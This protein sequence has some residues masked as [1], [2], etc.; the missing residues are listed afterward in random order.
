MA[1]KLPKLDHVKYVR[2]RGRVYA[3]FNTGRKSL[4]G[5]P[6]Y[7]RLPDPASPQFYDTYGAYKAGR[8]KRSTTAYMVPKLIA[9][10]L[11]SPDYADKAKATQN[12]YRIQLAKARD[13]LAEFPADDLQAEDLRAIIA[14]A[15]WGAG[16]QNAFIAAIGACYKWWRENGGANL[17]PTRGISARKTG[18]HEPWPEDVLEAA[19]K[20]DNARIRLAV[21]LLYCTGLR[22]GDA[23]NVR[24]GDIRDGELTVTPEKTKR[25]GKTLQIALA[26]D[27]KDELARTPRRS[28]YVLTGRKGGKQNI[29]Q[30]RIELQAFALEHGVKRNPHGLRKNAVNYLLEHGC[31]VPEVAAITGQTHQI[32]EHYAA[33]VNR[34]KLG[35]AAIVKFDAARK[36][37]A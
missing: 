27:L 33:K 5:H 21:H 16:T 12:L 4:K 13:L 25:H 6:V 18:Q 8:T 7:E 10:Y 31:T 24:W 35:Q 2:K 23:C 14:K 3:Y 28:L 29:D 26:A 20:S 37:S 30:L 9:D 19:L 11:A 22:I 17:E 34:R 32:V 15:G 1:R 36:K